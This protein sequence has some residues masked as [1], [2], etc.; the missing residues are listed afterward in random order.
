M[1]KFLDDPTP[2]YK[3]KFLDDD[4][5]K[6]YK[7]K[8]L[9]E[10]SPIGNKAPDY[11]GFE[12]VKRL[13]LVGPTGYFS[14][15]G[16]EDLIPAVGQTV[17]SVIPGVN[18]FGGSVAG[19]TAGQAVR[20]G[21][22]AIRGTRDSKPR[23]LFGIGPTAP[24]IVNDLAGEAGGTAAMEGI[25]RVGGKLLK[26]PLETAANRMMLSVLKPGRDVIKR[27]PRLGIE[28]AEL[29]ITGSKEGM[30]SKSENL[31]NQYEDQVKNFIQ[32]SNKRINAE[33]IIEAL[34]NAKTNAL[35]G[36]KHEDAYAIDTV[37]QN[38]ISRLPSKNVPIMETDALGNALKGEKTVP[39]Y[40]GL[41][42]EKG[43]NIK[44][45]IY[46]ETPDAAFNRSMQENPGATEAR[47]LVASG[48]RKEI[49]AAEPKISPILK[50]ESTAINVKKALEN[51]LANEQK[52]VLLPKLAGMGAG[53]L[54][55]SGN[56]LS[57]VGVLAGNAAFEAARSS[58]IV[59]GLAKNLLRLRK[60]GRPLTL[61]ASEAFRRLVR[62]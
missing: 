51:A 32:K 14:S 11:G 58:P 55:L 47:R 27:N 37:K 28:A 21:I 22:K 46:S 2:T 8:F 38:F 33:S 4:S 56:P 20:Q 52:K 44:K 15:S 6:N 41:N 34:D 54:A 17:G 26:K 59:T 16:S 10:N 9:D 29:G 57:G 53:G 36:L 30:L 7:G 13:A 35:N 19:A 40:L 50:K 60:A 23:K 43:Q 49:A 12:G 61:A 39:D 24:G 5:D 48:I 62:N 18:A 42:L 45:A 31:I 3:G 25:F 1:G